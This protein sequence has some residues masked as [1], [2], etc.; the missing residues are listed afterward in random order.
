MLNRGEKLGPYTI[1]GPISVRKSGQG[2]VYLAS[3]IDGTGSRVALKV[4]AEHLKFSDEAL[5]NFSEEA[6]LLTKLHHES[7]VRLESFDTSPPTP[8]IAQEYIEGRSVAEWVREQGAPPKIEVVLGIALQVADA[9][10]YAHDLTYFRITRTDTGGTSSHKCRGLIHRDLSTDNILVTPDLRVKLIDFGIAKAVGVTTVTTRNT[11]LGKEFYIAP[12]VEIGVGNTP[13]TSVDIYS[14][15]VC[16]YE[17]LMTLRPEK[18]RVRV[19]K[20]FHRNLHQLH[21]SFPDEVPDELKQLIVHCVQREPR[22]RPQT[23]AK[24]CECLRELRGRSAVLAQDR[25][26]ELPA[27]LALSG[28]VLRLR[29]LLELSR[30][31][32]STSI[33]NLSINEESTRLFLLDDDQTRVCSFNL[34]GGERQT[35]HVPH[36]ERLVGIAGGKGDGAFGVSAGPGSLLFLDASGEWRTLR[37]PV[38][39][40]P[41]RTLFDNIVFAKEGLYLGDYQENR[42]IRLASADGALVGGTPERLVAQLGPF[43]VGA[44]SV[45][46]VDLAAKAIL[47][48]DLGFQQTRTICSNQDWGWPTCL[49][50]G[51]NFLFLVD[52]QRK[53]VLLYTL[54]GDLADPCVFTWTDTGGV[55]QVVCI[56]RP[57]QVVLLEAS[58]GVLLFLDVVPI[59]VEALRLA[60]A[61]HLPAS[62]LPA[63]SYEA[64]ESVQLRRVHGSPAGKELARRSLVQLENAPRIGQQ[65]LKLQIAL[66][67]FLLAQ[68]SKQER[69]NLL[70]ALSEKLERAGQWQ[71]AR[72]VCQ[73][74]LRAV[75][76]FNPEMRDR[77]GRLLEREERWDEIR[78][79]EGE[80]LQA[81]F[82]D[83]PDA[84]AAYHPSYQRLRRAYANLGIPLPKN[85]SLPRAG[86][87][88]KARALLAAGKYEQARSIFRDLVDNEDYSQLKAEDAIAVLEGYALSIK[89]SLKDLT[90]EDWDEI[91]R[92]LQILVRDCSRSPA[93]KPEFERDMIAA[94]RQAAKMRGQ[95]PPGA[96]HAGFDPRSG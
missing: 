6:E 25:K 62:E 95:S 90:A 13:S 1:Q 11:S 29:R 58:K 64:V 67:D 69:V 37:N 75:Q 17:M 78:T 39:R 59:D 5:K 52:S 46:F 86:E 93:F 3:R 36:G 51:D 22:D 54:D 2:D 60:H 76:G 16:L 71:R 81:S 74:F 44:G 66:Y 24:V 27:G 30:E 15:G 31:R 12:E 73:E 32:R 65:G 20:Q 94:Q 57:P 82:F 85:L 43:G 72:E 38:T 45:F 79:F 10:S 68:A 28:K 70:R 47:R 4:L 7:I 48:S 40:E 8:Y 23:M 19:L 84:R 21:S 77:Y 83:N 88:A 55:T 35:R 33:T 80:F 92:S 50:V 14:F 9:L 26:A 41:P 42:I 18:E 87:A 63:I 61:L 34:H 49:A 96:T 91:F 89:R 53:C 56:S